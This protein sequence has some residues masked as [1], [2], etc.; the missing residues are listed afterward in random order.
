VLAAGGIVDAATFRAVL[1]AG[2]AG[3]RVGTR[4]V[5]TVES[6]AHPLYKQA[7]VDAGPDSTEITDVFAVCPLCASSTRRP[8]VLRAAI[9]AVR[10]FDGDVVGT[11]ALGGRTFDVPK[12]SG[13]P[14]ESSATGH[15]DAMAMYAGEGVGS[16]SAVVPAAALVEEFAGVRT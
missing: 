5:A 6:G 4:F 15:V 11:S 12:G 10:R 3:A 1:D 9:D 7:I 2:A 13:L 14:A 8:R 16:I